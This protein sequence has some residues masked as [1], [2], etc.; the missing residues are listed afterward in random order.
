MQTLEISALRDEAKNSR[1][2]YV[3]FGLG[4]FLRLNT[5]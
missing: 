3:S 4:N 1:V 5:K 2:D